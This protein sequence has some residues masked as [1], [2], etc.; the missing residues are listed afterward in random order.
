MESC[1]PLRHACGCVV[2]MRLL[3][4]NEV[5]ENIASHQGPDAN[6]S[7]RRN[8][9]RLG[10]GAELEL[11]APRAAILTNEPKILPRNGVGVEEAI[12]FAILRTLCVA[13]R[14]TAVYHDV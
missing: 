8:L 4:R 13:R 1:N 3:E 10:P 9:K 14:D 11:P 5:L 6:S 2:K 12:R 7:V